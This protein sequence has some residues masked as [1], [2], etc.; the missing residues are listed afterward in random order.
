MK[1]VV[2]EFAV[3]GLETV[4]GADVVGVDGSKLAAGLDHG[5]GA[6]GLAEGKVLL[7]GQAM[8]IRHFESDESRVV[9]AVAEAGIDADA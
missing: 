2:D 6:Q 1:Y 4:A 7:E 9:V 5:Y 3:K 8:P